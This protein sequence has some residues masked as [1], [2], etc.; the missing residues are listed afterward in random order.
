MLNDKE[1]FKLKNYLKKNKITQKS[2]AE[3]IGLH[4]IS[5]RRYLGKQR[6]PSLSMRKLIRNITE[7]EVD[8]NGKY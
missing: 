6:N 2:F 5:F 8:L 4:E 1:I 7:G 3:M